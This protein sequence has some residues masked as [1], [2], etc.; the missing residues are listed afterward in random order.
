MAAFYGSNYSSSVAVPQEQIPAGEV[1]GKVRM[2]FDSFTCAQDVYAIADT[3]DMGK[4]LPIGARIVDAVVISE[5][6]GTT[7]IFDLGIKSGDVD[8]FVAGVDAGGQVDKQRMASEAGLL[9]QGA[10]VIQPC[11]KF[12]EASDAA[13]GKIIQMA[14]FYVLE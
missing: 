3:I 6:L 10:A 1:S 11:I 5:S 4:S 13:D 12:T 9:V 2:C 8:Y 14:I 7:G